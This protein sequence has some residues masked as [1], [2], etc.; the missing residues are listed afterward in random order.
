MPDARLPASPGMNQA[1]PGLP[2]GG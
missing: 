2:A 1:R